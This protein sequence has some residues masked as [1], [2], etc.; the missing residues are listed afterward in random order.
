MLPR[1]V[2]DDKKTNSSQRSSQSAPNVLPFKRIYSQSTQPS[3]SHPPS[4]SIDAS[5]S[6]KRPKKKRVVTGGLQEFALALVGELEDTVMYIRDTHDAEFVRWLNNHCFEAVVEGQ[7][8]FVISTSGKSST[9]VKPF[10][11]A[12]NNFYV[13]E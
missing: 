12:G 1:F 6:E 2:I 9:T 10:P 11:I 3:Q 5:S 4:F 13:T 7:T 8:A